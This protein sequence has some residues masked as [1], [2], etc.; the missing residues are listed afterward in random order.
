MFSNL[1]F[2]HRGKVFLAPDF[3]TGLRSLGFLTANLANKEGGKEGIQYFII[4]SVFFLSKSASSFSSKLIFSH[5]FLLLLMY[6]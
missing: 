2:L 4:F 3:L 5:V 6:L 1:V